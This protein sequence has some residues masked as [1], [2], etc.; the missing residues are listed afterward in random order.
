MAAR[1]TSAESPP[2]LVFV[3]LRHVRR[4]MHAHLWKRCA[5]SVVRFHPRVP[6]AIIDDGSA[7]EL[8]ADTLT[9]V[10]GVTCVI[11]S[12]FPGAGEL[13]P[14]HYFL[15]GRVRA[16]T[17]IFL[18]DSMYLKRP[19]TRAEL[20]R[21]LGFLWH[22]NPNPDRTEII[23]EFCRMIGRREGAALLA[24]FTSNRWKGCFGSATI[25]DH[26]MLGLMEARYRFISK[27]LPVIRTRPQREA[28]ERIL[29]LITMTM[30]ES[31]LATSTTLSLFGP[32]HLHPHFFNYNREAT[33]EELRNYD[34]AVVKTWKWR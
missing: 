11:Q 8:V 18:H 3:I 28:L 19:F 9:A 31:R 23:L 20:A 12:E 32:I 29:A 27:L 24:A 22:F 25:I 4:R 17:M 26:T 13:L 16:R 2:P 10:P 1:G 14:Y 30:P 15:Q 34:T 33:E 6:I 7:Q 21:G 5:E